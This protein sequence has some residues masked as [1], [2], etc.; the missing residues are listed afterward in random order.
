MNLP[1]LPRLSIQGFGVGA[2]LA[3]L[4]LLS[5]FQNASALSMKA[6]AQKRTAAYTVPVNE[7]Y[8]IDTQ[9]YKEHSLSDE[10]FDP[11]ESQA[12]QFD[13]RMRQY[14]MDR[15]PFDNAMGAWCQHRRF[16]PA[17]TAP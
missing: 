8:L 1:F 4:S 6:S 12:M 15:M 9:N 7:S 17:A 10:V 5:P 16:F 14:E 3:L 11:R 13:Y 2:G